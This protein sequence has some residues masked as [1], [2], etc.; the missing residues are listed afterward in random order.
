MSV[1]TS[2]NGNLSEEQ[3]A[4]LL[5]RARTRDPEALAALCEQFYPKLLRYMHYRVHPDAAEDLAADVLVRVIRSIDKQTGSFVAWVYKIAA[6]VVADHGRAGK[7]RRERPMDERTVNT[8]ADAADVSGDVERQLDI[9][10]ALTRLT[11]DQRELV[12]L[13]FIQGL[14][15]AEVGEATGRKPEAVR[16]LQFRALRA[17][18]QILGGENDE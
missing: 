16:G 5:A 3:N 12:T 14:S 17:L 18:R 11:G 4:R 1:Y 2:R 8:H 15:N 13:K 10:A 6:N 7:V 9:R